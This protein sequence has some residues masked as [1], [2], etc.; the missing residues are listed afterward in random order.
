M[1]KNIPRKGAKSQKAQ[2]KQ[3]SSSLGVF[4][5]WSRGR[6]MRLFI[7]S[8][9]LLIGVVAASSGAG[10]SAAFCARDKTLP[11]CPSCGKNNAA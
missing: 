1:I 2:R 9:L 6:G 10:L 7:F 4:A 5:P 3:S 8:Q 11:I